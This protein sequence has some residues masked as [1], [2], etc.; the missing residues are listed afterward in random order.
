MINLFITYIYILQLLNYSL[1]HLCH[2]Q[3]V[4]PK[5]MILTI[6]LDGGAHI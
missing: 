3:K 5:Y 1:K 4:K 6:K 2:W